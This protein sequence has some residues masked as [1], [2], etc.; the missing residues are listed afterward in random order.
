MKDFKLNPETNIS[1]LFTSE[2][3]GLLTSK[4]TELVEKM[5]IEIVRGVVLD[6]LCGKN[7]R[8]STESLTRKR[9]ASI[10]L[11]ILRMFILGSSADPDFINN[12]P[13]IA[14]KRLQQKRLAKEE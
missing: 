4:G 11:A 6:V 5:G 2:A 14:G 7:L 8:D 1:S 10:N 13:T 3:L 12:L 9:I